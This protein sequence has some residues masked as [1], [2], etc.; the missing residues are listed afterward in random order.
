MEK[1]TDV[2]NNAL[3]LKKEL[4]DFKVSTGKISDR[5]NGVGDIW[6]DNHHS[7]LQERISDLAKAS[8]AVIENGEKT[9]VC[10]DHFFNIVA[11]E[12]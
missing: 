6:R 7:L 5:I 11:E 9:C 3:S 2:V 10:V 1:E 8:R 12:I 4:E